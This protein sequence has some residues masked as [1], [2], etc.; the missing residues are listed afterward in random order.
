MRA[1]HLDFAEHVLVSYLLPGLVEINHGAADVEEGDHLAAV[2]GNNEGVDFPRRLVDEASLVGNPIVLE[3]APLAPDHVPDD[4]HRMA[5]ARQHSRAAHAQQVAPP[6]AD[7]VQQQRTEPD[8]GGLRNPDALVTRNRRDCDLGD[9]PEARQNRGSAHGISF[10]A[11]VS[12]ATSRSTSRSLG[13]GLPA[14][15][16]QYRALPKSPST[17]CTMP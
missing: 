17:M 4:D 1:T 12:S 8:V 7:R 5:V 10:S 6:A 11:E 15:R 14:R 2:V 16:Y 3:I 13:N 9:D